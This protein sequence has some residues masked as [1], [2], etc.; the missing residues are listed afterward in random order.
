[1]FGKKQNHDTASVEHGDVQNIADCPC[2][3]MQTIQT[4][5]STAHLSY[6]AGTQ[7]Y[8]RL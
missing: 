6:V 4:Y 8:E 3:L 5:A 1:M 7:K 2:Y